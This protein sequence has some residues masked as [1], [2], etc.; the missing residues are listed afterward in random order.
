M[1]IPVRI[2][3]TYRETATGRVFELGTARS[4]GRVLLIHDPGGP[5]REVIDYLPVE[6]LAE[7]FVFLACNHVGFCC[8]EHRIH[9]Q[10]HRGCLLR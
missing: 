5:D 2:G 3:A 9:V 4:K 10:P 1:S 7:R 8:R 6:E